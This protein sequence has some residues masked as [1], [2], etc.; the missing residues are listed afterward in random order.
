VPNQFYSQAELEAMVAAGHITP[1]QVPRHVG[2]DKGSMEAEIQKGSEEIVQSGQGNHGNKGA[3]VY[4]ESEL[5]GT[6]DHTGQGEYGSATVVTLG[7]I[8]PLEPELDPHIKPKP[9]TAAQI[10]AE[11]RMR[12][13]R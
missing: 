1:D 8:D 5:P 2:A 11:L 7:E 13:Q 6:N 10:I 4:D 12:Q 3:P 9:R